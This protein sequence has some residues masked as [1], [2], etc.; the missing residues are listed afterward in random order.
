MSRKPTRREPE[1]TVRIVYHIVSKATNRALDCF[2]TRSA[3]RAALPL[4]PNCK[5]RRS[6]TVDTVRKGGGA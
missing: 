6:K 4:H 2:V 1:R 5:I 3:A